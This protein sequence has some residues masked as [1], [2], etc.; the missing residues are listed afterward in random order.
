MYL[1]LG[2]YSGLKKRFFILLG[3]F[4]SSGI[5]YLGVLFVR[6][7]YS[8]PRP[9]MTKGVM[10]LID[11]SNEALSSFPSAH[12]AVF[13]ALGTFLYFYHTRLGALYLIGAALIGIAR[14]MAGVHWPLD[15]V[16]GAALGVAS[17]HLIKWFTQGIKRN[18]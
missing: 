6:A 2:G 11:K 16:A 10:P 14:V 18:L 3:S 17:A 7:F 12:A 1:F 4:V 15:I 5:G 9:F 8:S 13:F